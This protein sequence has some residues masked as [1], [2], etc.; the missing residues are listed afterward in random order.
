MIV[1]KNN[2]GNIKLFRIGCLFEYIC[3]DSGQ[4]EIFMLVNLQV[5]HIS[6]VN[7]VCPPL[8]RLFFFYLFAALLKLVLVEIFY[9]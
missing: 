5:M 9:I 7:D 8:E 2:F 6:Q 3:I 4:S 1:L